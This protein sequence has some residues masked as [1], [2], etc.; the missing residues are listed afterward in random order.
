[1]MKR[2]LLPILLFFVSFS[3]FADVTYNV[4]V[5][6]GTKACYI[7]GAMNGWSQQEMTKLTETTYTLTI[8]GATT[9]QK[10]KYCSGPNWGYVEKQANCTSD[11]SDRT[12]AANDV[13]ACWAA[14]Y[15]PAAPKVDVTIKVKTPASWAETRIHYWGDYS[16]SWPGDIMTKEGNWFVK[17]FSQINTI[18]IIFNDNAGNQTADILN[19]TSSTCYQVNADKSYTVIPCTND[20]PRVTYHVKVPT[21][22][23]SCYIAGEMTKP[24]WSQLEMHKVNDSIYSITVDSAYTTQHYKYCSGPSW[25]YVEKTADNQDKQNRTWVANDTVALW[26]AVYQPITTVTNNKF[27][28]NAL[29]KIYHSNLE[30]VAENEAEIQVY[31]IQGVLFTR[32]VNNHLLLNDMKPG[33]Y[34]IRVNDQSY[35]AVIQ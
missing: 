2:L 32:V 6:A 31:T 12:Y 13:V 33:V 16:S 7:A 34:I 24:Q 30:I 23:K 3:A 15:T 20:T 1:M 28:K 29:L 25:D 5:P 10:Y 11:I 22:T 17:T 14:V 26:N 4:T 18:S 19:V 27:H 21:G 8:V 35:K 9:D